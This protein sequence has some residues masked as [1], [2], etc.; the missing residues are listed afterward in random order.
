MRVDTGE[1]DVRTVRNGL[2]DLKDGEVA[3][4]VKSDGSVRQRGD[5]CPVLL[6]AAE[7]DEQFTIGPRVM[8]RGEDAPSM[9]HKT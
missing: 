4:R 1:P 2:P 6:D 5:R 3:F 9:H 7:P 8:G